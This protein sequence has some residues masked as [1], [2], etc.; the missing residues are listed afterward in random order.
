MSDRK[1]RDKGDRQYALKRWKVSNSF[2]SRLLREL[3]LRPI[4][5]HVGN[6]CGGQAI[7]SMVREFGQRQHLAY[8]VRRVW[9][10]SCGMTAKLPAC[11]TKLA[12]A[13]L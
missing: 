5:S 3:L 11:L 6:R 9:F 7:A 13:V 4:V 8:K 1:L 2:S 12:R 10:R